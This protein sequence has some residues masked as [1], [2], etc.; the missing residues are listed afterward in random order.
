M[1]NEK[2][3]LAIIPARGGSKR[4][5]RKNVLSIAGK[6]L[7]SWSIEAAK[8]SKY[9]DKIKVSTDNVEIAAVA[10]EFGVPTPFLRPEELASDTA[11]TLSVILHELNNSVE[12]VDIVIVLQPT[13]PLRTTRHI[14][15]AIELFEQN[16]AVSVVSVTECEHSPLWTNTL[17][18]NR[19]MYNFITPEK[20]KR[21]QDLDTYF[22]LNGA[23][24]IYDV[25]TLIERNAIFYCKD[26]Y[27]YV[28][29][30]E[31][32]VDIDNYQ[33]FKL[34]EFLILGT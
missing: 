1:I 19:S 14:D 28:M 9:I 29:G 32:S 16:I 31:F 5:P 30:S 11:T 25:S 18:K 33:D 17:P 23:I 7:I 3:I 21:S 15:E 34:A 8:N 24:Y 2:K 26:T 22:R 27:A 6:P 12:D 4:L 10:Q 20:L 13:S